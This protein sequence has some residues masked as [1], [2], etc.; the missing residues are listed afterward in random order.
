MRVTGRTHTGSPGLAFLR[1]LV[2]LVVL[3]LVLPRLLGAVADY[4]FPPAAP[5][6]AQPALSRAIVSE[7]AVY[8]EWLTAVII[9][10]HRLQRGIE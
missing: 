4:L 8:Q 2:I 10:W 7:R 3:G 6:A 1:I 5:G 9:W